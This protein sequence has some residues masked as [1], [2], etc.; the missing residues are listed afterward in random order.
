[1]TDTETRH[2]TR[3]QELLAIKEA[4]KH[5][6]HYLLGI[7]FN[8]HSDHHSLQYI[9]SQKELSGKL[10]RWCDFL[11]QFDFSNI[12]YL[13]GPQNPIGDALLRPP[14]GDRDR[15]PALTGPVGTH[16][17]LEVML[18]ETERVEVLYNVELSFPESV[19]HEQIR[20]HLSADKQ[21]SKNFNEVSAPKYNPSVS[22]YHNCYT[23]RDD[24]LYFHDKTTVRLCVPAK[25]R[26][27]LLKEIQDTPLAGHMGVT[28]THNAMAR[29]YYWSDMHKDIQ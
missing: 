5:W 28:R 23:L 25:V 27:L 24:L 6:K 21:F 20:E 8:I 2:T 1:M 19:L 7:S 9:F 18:C 14:L 15:D 12:Q 22:K 4:L 10:L 13:P 3:E 11:Q 16:A 26:P 17:S 29:D